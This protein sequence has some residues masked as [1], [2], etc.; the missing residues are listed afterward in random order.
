MLKQLLEKL[1]CK[2]KWKR[3]EH[4]S[5]RNKD[6]YLYACDVCGKIKNLTT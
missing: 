2:H 6:S 5:Y 3:I 4:T 1:L